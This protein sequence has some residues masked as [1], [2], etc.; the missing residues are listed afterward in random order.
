MNKGL[1]FLL[2]LC[3]IHSCWADALSLQSS[4]FKNNSLIPIEYTCYGRD[5]S[6]PLTWSN[7][8]QNTRSLA[9][10]VEDPDAPSGTW[11]HWVMFNIPP[12][13]TELLSGA[14]APNGAAQ[15]KNSWGSN[16]YRGPCPTLGM[17]QYVFKLY[18]L[19]KLLNY[20]DGADK[21]AVLN[22]MTGHVLGSAQWV[23]LYQRL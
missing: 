10:V 19:D 9:L 14:P 12:T 15:G 1:V 21:D 18:A 17:H 22:A 11:T 13:L 16:H 4:A 23:G 6:P 20:T 3:G 7:I 2:A 5:N 8:P